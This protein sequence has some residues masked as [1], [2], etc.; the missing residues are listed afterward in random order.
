MADRNSKTRRAKKHDT[1]KYGDKNKMALRIGG[2][3]AA[4]SE[5]NEPIESDQVSIKEAQLLE[6][7][8]SFKAGT[9]GRDEAARLAEAISMCVVCVGANLFGC[10]QYEP[11][12]VEATKALESIGNRFVRTGKWGATGGELRKL[13]ELIELRVAIYGHEENTRGLETAACNQVLAEI[14]RG[15]V[16]RWGRPMEEARAA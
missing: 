8:A 4:I 7:I 1:E 14:E 3:L 11:M 16:I 13:G 5:T 10:G 12:V 15:N 2:R 6:A 9:A